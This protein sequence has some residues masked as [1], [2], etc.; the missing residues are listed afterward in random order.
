MNGVTLKI[1][2]T[3]EGGQTGETNEKIVVRK[4]IQLVEW[5]EPLRIRRAAD[6]EAAVVTDTDSTDNRNTSEDC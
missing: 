5:T 4:N 1:N 2:V 6:N 3:N